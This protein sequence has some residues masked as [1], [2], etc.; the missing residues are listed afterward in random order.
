MKERK[1]RRKKKGFGYTHIVSITHIS[2]LLFLIP[3]VFPTPYLQ[4]PSPSS[5]APSE[6]S[7]EKYSGT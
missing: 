2:F 4:S 7:E 1:C 3:S 6:W 5:A